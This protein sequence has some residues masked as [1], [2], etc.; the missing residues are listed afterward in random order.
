MDEKMGIMSQRSEEERVQG[1]SINDAKSDL[2]I[3]SVKLIAQVQ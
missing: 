2:S 3:V 1:C